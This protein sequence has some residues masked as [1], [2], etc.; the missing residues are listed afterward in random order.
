MTYSV[1]EHWLS[2]CLYD[3]IWYLSGE[4]RRSAQGTIPQT[5]LNSCASP[6]KTLLGSVFSLSLPGRE[7][8]AVAL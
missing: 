4:E 8:K 2:V 6:L 3:Q 1:G 7:G 5:T